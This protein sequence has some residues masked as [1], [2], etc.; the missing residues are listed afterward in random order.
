MPVES[1]S[2]ITPV[3][4]A[5]LPIGHRSVLMVAVVS[6]PLGSRQARQSGAERVRR[7][8]RHQ[9]ER[10][11]SVLQRAGR[12]AWSPPREATVRAWYDADGDQTL[13]L[14]YDLRP[15]SIVLDV[16]GYEGQWASD[17]F[18]RYACEV[19]VF[20]PVPAFADQIRRRFAA[21]PSIKVH[22]VALGDRTGTFTI[23]VRGDSSTLVGGGT[24]T[25]EVVAADEKLRELGLTE[26]DL[27]KLN[28]EGAEYDL[29]DHLLVNGWL[30]HIRHLQVQF[31]DFVPRAVERMNAIQTALEHTHQL[32]YRYEFV[33]E[34][35]ERKPA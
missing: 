35:W 26:I 16:G 8:L 12:A 15:D 33:W 10:A 34:S 30:P 28:I 7:Q 14:D 20:E 4:Y 19:H 5:D 13:R 6:P 23:D 18:G 3:P 31:H 9:L 25:V 2:I 27:V 29:L 24:D 1:D 22:P 21:N 17:I 11:A 32:M